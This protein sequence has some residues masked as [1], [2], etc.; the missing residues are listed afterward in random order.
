LQTLLNLLGG[1][2]LESGDCD[3]SLNQTMFG[4]IEAGEIGP[5]ASMAN[6]SQNDGPVRAL[7]DEATR[8]FM[9]N[10]RRG[11]NPARQALGWN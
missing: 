6:F 4:S 8:E 10:A 7:V 3:R 5:S 2:K 11:K 9:P 1:Q